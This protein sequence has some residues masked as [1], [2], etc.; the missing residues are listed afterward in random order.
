MSLLCDICI[1]IFYNQQKKKLQPFADKHIVCI[2]IKFDF[3]T[4]VTSKV[5]C[6]QLFFL[7][8]LC[9]FTYL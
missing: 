7:Y 4:N 3:V 5:M 2:V 9:F 6:S 1:K 8:I